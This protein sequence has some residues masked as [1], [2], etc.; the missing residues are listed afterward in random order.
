[1]STWS[2]QGGYTSAGGARGRAG[3]GNGQGME[4]STRREKRHLSGTGQHLFNNT[5]T[6][7]SG[8]SVCIIP[9]FDLLR[10]V[11]LSC[12]PHKTFYVPKTHPRGSVFA[13]AE[14]TAGSGTLGSTAQGQ[15]LGQGL[16]QGLGQGLGQQGTETSSV[17]TNSPSSRRS[18][19]W[20]G[21]E[22]TGEGVGEGEE[23]HTLFPRDSLRDG[24]RAGHGFW[25][26]E[27]TDL[28]VH[29][30]KVTSPSLPFPPLSPPY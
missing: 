23:S 26:G 1:M 4:F 7:S 10:T 24:N 15:G 29:T 20:G 30:S 25:G 27:N 14:A 28:H 12:Q 6:T 13:G 5:P 3:Q 8:S 21:G 19:D 9:F 22:G 17:S 2:R 18:G 16:V 11:A